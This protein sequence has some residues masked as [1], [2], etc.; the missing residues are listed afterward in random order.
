MALT[1]PILNSIA[2]FD[3]TQDAVFTFI[4]NGGDKV[5]GSKLT[6]KTNDTGETV[7]EETQET[8][9]KQ[10]IL[11]ANTLTNN[12]YYTASIQSMNAAGTLSNPSSSIQFWC[13]TSPTIEFTN[14]PSDNIIENSSF[15][16]EATYNQSEGELLSS[17]D[18][19]LYD[20][21][22]NI[23]KGITGDDRIYIYEVFAP[24]THISYMFSGLEDGK[25]Y[26]IEIVGYTAHKTEV[27]S[28]KH[29]FYV[30]Y[31]ITQFTTGIRLTNQC[32]RGTIL[33]EAE[34]KDLIGKLLAKLDPSQPD[35]SEKLDKIIKLIEEFKHNCDCCKSNEGIIDDLEKE[36]E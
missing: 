33:I 22:D 28:E 35:Y 25:T 8:I 11:P 12:K 34:L 30:E 7:Y 16:F 13:Y 27:H 20:E 5:T 14:I 26:K 15:T 1:R 9:L 32:Q 4:S 36:L 2:A 3:S 24:P 31:G 10:H 29:I 21:N 18:I 23:V 6:I 17:Y 19:F